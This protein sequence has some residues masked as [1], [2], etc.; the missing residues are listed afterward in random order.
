M[1]TGLFART[2]LPSGRIFDFST[3]TVNSVKTSSL[4]IISWVLMVSYAM[5]SLGKGSSTRG[6]K[7]KS[8]L[9][10]EDFLTM[11]S[12]A[13]LAITGVV[14]KFAGAGAKLVTVAAGLI[15]LTGTAEVGKFTGT[16][17]KLV[18]VAA[19]P[20]WLTGTA[21][22]LSRVQAMSILLETVAGWS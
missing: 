9:L 10:G 18:T 6:S 5:S 4:E 13:I 17:A 8:C 15:W 7:S 12:G 19:G 20:I 3:G 16:G 2:V 11:T 1:K 22:P 14:G 21:V